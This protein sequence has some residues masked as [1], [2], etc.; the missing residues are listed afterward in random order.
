VPVNISSYSLL[1]RMVAQCVN[2]IPK[3]FIWTGGDCHIYPDQEE[4]VF[5]QITR[6]PLDLPKIWI[7][8]DVK[9]IF[10]FTMEDFK[11][12]GYRYHPKIVYEVA[13]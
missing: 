9:D 11:L 1:T 10:S 7:N 3:E 12:I 2:M 13:I 4:G 8:P 6:Q 5:N